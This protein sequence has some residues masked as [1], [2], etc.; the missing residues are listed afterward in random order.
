MLIWC[1]PGIGNSA[2]IRSEPQGLSDQQDAA[3]INQA[4]KQMASLA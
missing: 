1:R 4:A 2:K 3:T